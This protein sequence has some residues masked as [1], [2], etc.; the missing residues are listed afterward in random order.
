MN[1]SGFRRSQ[2][3]EQPVATDTLVAMLM[4]PLRSQWV[5][6]YGYN[7]NYKGLAGAK[8]AADFPTFPPAD[9]QYRPL[10]QV[11]GLD[12]IQAQNTAPPFKPA[13]SLNTQ[14]NP[15]Q[16]LMFRGWVQQNNVP[17]NPNTQGPT[18]YDMRGYY[19]GLQQW[20]PMAR[21]TGIN[22]NDNLPHYPDYY[23]TPLHQSF[24]SES[25][26]AGPNAPSWINDSQLANPNGQVV[27]DEKPTSFAAAIAK[28]LSG[29]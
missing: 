13:T 2:N 10:G 19:Q 17:F 16:E 23:K 24:S 25:Q 15:L 12:S 9:P 27:F 18:D 6:P 20:N 22:P 3:V 8:T 4:N 21:P 1:Y 14:L 5:N 28:L 29:R 26:W 7:E 11:L